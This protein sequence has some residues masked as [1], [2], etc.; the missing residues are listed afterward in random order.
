MFGMFF[1]VPLIFS[2]MGLQELF[3]WQREKLGLHI[4]HVLV[5]GVVK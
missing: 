2:D 3:F 1:R 4:L 5:V